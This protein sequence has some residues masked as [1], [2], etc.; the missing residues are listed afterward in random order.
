MDSITVDKSALL[1]KLKT[2]RDEHHG[3]FERAQEAY[4]EKVIEALDRA[5]ADAKEGRGLRTVVSLPVPE[6]HTA[7]F[8]RAIE[9]LDWEQGDSVVLSEYEFQQYVQNEWS[10]RRTFA[11]NTASYVGS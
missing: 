2:N 10:W 7:E 8:D 9:M 3:I 1:A 5:L 11:A 4:R 6:D